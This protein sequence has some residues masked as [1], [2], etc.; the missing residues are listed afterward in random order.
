LRRS[1]KKI[2]IDFLLINFVIETEIILT[3]S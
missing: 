2:V 3:V 1:V